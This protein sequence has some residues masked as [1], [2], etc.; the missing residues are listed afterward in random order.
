MK[1][2]ALL[3][4]TIP[5]TPQLFRSV[6]LSHSRYEEYRKKERET[7][8]DDKNN[9]QIEIID[10]EIKD[11]SSTEQMLRKSVVQL[12]REF[13]ELISEAEK[14]NDFSLVFK[15]NALKRKSEEK[16]CEAETLHD[17]LQVLKEKRK[18]LF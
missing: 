15:G 3:P 8:K 7:L 5:M 4:S 17:A 13:I 2:N 18:K 10:K 6:K 14:K 9:K 12:D 16:K 1:K 11:I